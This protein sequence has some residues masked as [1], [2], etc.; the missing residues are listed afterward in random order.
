MDVRGRKLRREGEEVWKKGEKKLRR[1]VR[2]QA[3]CE[4]ETLYW[5]GGREIKRPCLVWFGLG[6]PLGGV[7]RGRNELLAVMEKGEM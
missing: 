3:A 7:M 2:E 5:R 4:G 1:C 6:K